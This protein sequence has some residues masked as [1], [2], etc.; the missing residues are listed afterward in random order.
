MKK[1]YVG[2]SL[3]NVEAVR[4]IQARFAAIGVGITYDWTIAGQ[5][6]DPA[7]LRRVGDLEMAGVRDCDLFFMMQPARNGT[8][9]ELGMALAWWKPIVLLEE[10]KV[11]QKTFY[12]N[13]SVYRF[14]DE[15]TAF[16]FAKEFLQRLT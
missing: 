10:T 4:R 16:A 9:C 14:E 11:E 15:E 12:Y 5:I 7:E 3:H 2:S 13:P 8:H 6:T 1:V